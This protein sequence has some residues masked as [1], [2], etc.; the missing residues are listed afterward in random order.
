MCN[1]T[2]H[3]GTFVVSDNPSTASSLDILY[4]RV[5]PN[6]I[7]N[8][9]GR[10]DEVRCHPGTRKEVINRIEKWRD[11]QDGLT[12]PIFWLSGPAGAG[13]S[14]IVQTVADRCIQQEVPQAN[15]FF[16]RADSSRNTVAPLVATLLHQII[17]LYSSVR[18]TVA[19][20]LS[21]N[22][23]IFDGLLE[24]QLAQLIIAPLRA[25]Q[26]SS[27]SYKP[28]TLFVDGLDECDSRDNQRRI[29]HAFGKVLVK[30]PCLF[31][32]LVGSR[33]ESQIK[34][35]FKQLSTPLLPLYLDAKYSPDRDIRRFVIAEFQKIREAHP[36]C[37][38]LHVNWPSDK[39]IEAIVHKSSGQFV[40]AATAMRF[41]SHSSASPN[42]SLDRVQ[43]VAQVATN[44]PFSQLDA[45]YT[46]ILS[47]ADDQQ[48][49]KDILHA[50]FHRRRVAH[51]EAGPT[52]TLQQVLCVYDRVY[53]DSVLHS[54]IADVNA[55]A[56]FEND[57]LIF[58][59]ASLADYLEDQSRS[60]EYFVDIDVFNVKILQRLLRHPKLDEKALRLVRNCLES[61]KA[62]T[63]DIMRELLAPECLDFIGASTWTLRILSENLHRL[64]L[65][66]DMTSYKVILRKWIFRYMA[67][68]FG[69][70][71]NIGDLREELHDVPFG[72]RYLMMAQIVHHHGDVTQDLTI[73]TDTLRPE[74]NT[75]EVGLWVKE[76]LQRIHKKHYSDDYARYKRLVRL[77]VYWAVSNSVLLSNV[78][79]LLSGRQVHYM[80]LGLSSPKK[81]ELHV[82]V[83]FSERYIM[84]AQIEHLCGD[85]AQNLDIVTD[86]LRSTSAFDAHET[87]VWVEELLGRIHEEYYPRQL[88]TYKRLMRQWIFWAVSNNVFTSN[89]YNFPNGRHIADTT[90]SIVDGVRR[91]ELHDFPYSQRYITMARIETLQGGVY[92]DLGI[93][94][95]DALRPE[96]VSD[97][98]EVALWVQHLL[99]RIYR[100]CYSHDYSRYRRLV[101]MWVYWAVSNNVPLYNVQTLLTGHQIC[102]TSLGL[103]SL[104]EDDDIVPSSNRYIMMALVEHLYGDIV[105]NLITVSDTLRSTSAFDAHEASVWVEGLLERIHG[106]YYP[107]RLETYKRLIRRWIFWAVSNNVFTSNMYNFRNCRTIPDTTSS[108][109]YGGKIKKPH[110][111]PY[112]QRYITMARIEAL[113]GDVGQD[114]GVVAIDALHSNSISDAHE[115]ALW[116]QHLLKHIYKRFYSCRLE[117]YERL[118][119]Q[120]IYWAVSNNVLLSNV[121]TL[122]N[123]HQIH[124]MSLGLSGLKEY[125]P[126]SDIVPLS[127]MYIMMAQIEHC[128]GDITQNFDIVADALRPE[129]NTYEIGLWVK[130]L[131][132]SIHKKYYSNDIHYAKY[133]RLVRQWIYWAVSNYVLS[134]NVQS[135]PNRRQIHYISLGLSDLR[136]DN[137]HDDILPLS[138]TYIMMAQIEHL[139]GDTAQ[140][141]DMVT[142][143]LRST[144]AFD[145]HETSVWVEG[146]LERIHGEYYPHRLETYK[147]LI[148]QWIFCAVSN[149]VFTSNM[150]NFRNC[151]TAPDTT[152]STLYSRERE[153][154]HDI[155]YRQRYITMARIEALRG[156]VGQDFDVV[157]I[158]ALRP[159]SVSDAHE[160]ALWVQ[161]LLKRVYEEYYPCGLETYK[162]LIRQWIYWAISNN[163]LS[164]NVQTLPNG[165]QIHYMSMGLSG[166]KE[167]GLHCDMVPLSEMYIMMAQIEHSHGD[168]TQNLDVVAD[169]LRPETNNHEVGLWVKTLLQSIYTKYDSGDIHYAKYKQLIRQWIYWAVSNCVLSFNVKTLPNG[170]QI[171][172]MS[173]GLSDL[174]EDDLHG[175][176]VPLSDRYMVMAQIEHLHGDTAQDLDIVA[177]TLL[178]MSAFD[179]YETSVWVEKLLGRIHGEYYPHRLETYKRLIRQWIF[180]AVSNNVFTSNMYKFGVR[181]GPPIPDA[182][183]STLYNGE[184]KELHDLPYIQRYI[185]MARIE[186][187]RGD[188]DQDLCIVVIDALRPESV[189]DAHEVGLWVQHLLQ[190]IYEEFYPHS[191]KTYKRLTRKWIF[192]AVS[193]D[194]TLTDFEKNEPDDILPCSQRYFTMAQIERLFGDVSQ[195]PNLLVDTLRERPE[196]AYDAHETALWVQNLLQ[197]IHSE[198]YLSHLDIYKRLMKQWICWALVNDVALADLDNLPYGRWYLRRCTVEKRVTDYLKP[199]HR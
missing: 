21:A 142:E 143:T 177:D 144:L 5:A 11:A 13:K 147:R 96:S 194:I 46:F 170:R 49:L 91:K 99:K 145:A 112:R 175:D 10:A 26:R 131:L 33:D 127:E 149:N 133:K 121:K 88:T 4:K 8:A 43:G 140:D 117:T 97:A 80:S 156:D 87:S 169:A 51:P 78:Q 124:Y 139:H 65:P 153:E 174:R 181:N 199:S 158:N 63:P 187:L 62:M 50:H 25:I 111:I 172:Y 66:D 48:A 84:M 38:M 9:E 68:A 30:H 105:E 119:R 108:M 141:L 190:R 135:L 132:Q 31:C 52:L 6:A 82:T 146:L 79:T 160:V 55:I 77:W 18:D 85:I 69:C 95:I 167:N 171:R 28:L 12:A 109:L 3:G 155:P 101:R 197:R 100:E 134:F 184:R 154:P 115:V 114:L 36:L 72:Q 179:A 35:A 157:A 56:C 76:L 104:L 136:E 182:T 27:D 128:H 16:F 20:V 61:L 110:D 47:R 176:I 2:I 166:L 162:R 137:L 198:Y 44:S 185:T 193:N 130:K 138:D 64:C 163:V 22:P 37:H 24:E 19:A 106:E 186:T 60:E 90:S 93:V 70:I 122:P 42:L 54:C 94:A 83:P 123:G 161:H 168:V 191:L 107:H 129:T 15:F 58:Y 86:T 67:L 75:H 7:L 173:L 73:V 148:K 152:S 98:P 1:T 92:L 89:V 45:I 102:Y 151:R 159:E 183:P 23:L 53:T 34:M 57:S 103:P 195:N 74:F 39:D 81:N 150:Y 165:R 178:S 188:V 196:S 32:L 125:G 41:I 113:R 118:T 71:D 116:V 164:P 14:A 180:W 17:L 120:W 126:N 59:H 192:W 29:I 189:S 40:Y